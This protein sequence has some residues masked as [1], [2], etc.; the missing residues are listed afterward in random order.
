VARVL[1]T[2]ATGFIGT[3]L[4]PRLVAAG[5]VPRMMVRQLPATAPAPPVEVVRGDLAEP[6]SLR[7]ALEGCQ[8]V[9]HLGA[10]TS[11]GR[12]DPAVAYRVNVG[13]TT[14]LIDACRATGCRRVLVMSTQHVHLPNC[15]LYGR[16]KRIADTL[17]QDSGLD[18]TVL[19]PSLVYGPGSRGVFVKL[20]GLVRKLPVIPVIGPGQWHLRPLYLDDLLTIIVDTLGR[21]ELAGRTYDVG[22]PDRVTYD[23][24]LA[25]I[26]AALGRPC[27]RIH[28]PIRVSFVLA[29]ILERLLPAPPL[30]T[31]NVYGS[32][33][34]APCDLTALT[35]DFHPT[36]TPLAD[37][38][39][40]ALPAIAA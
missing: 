16:T 32:L 2:G 13:G 20:A 8:A 31:E 39:R 27:R 3:G 25:A 22:G 23:E 5:H 1:V 11:A 37:G 15:G 17:L 24:M 18:V 38:L 34:E 12:I 14:A 10:S 35:R 7:P 40:R 6:P 28:L 36:L 21:P 33:L 29:W 30:T 26:C 4:V 19:R 9:V